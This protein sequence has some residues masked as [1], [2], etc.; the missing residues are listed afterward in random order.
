M[1]T[2]SYIGVLCRPGQRGLWIAAGQSI[3][4][5]VVVVS[6]N[7]TMQSMTLMLFSCLKTTRYLVL[8]S[9]QV[10][11]DTVTPSVATGKRHTQVGTRIRV[12]KAQ[13]GCTCHE[14]T[15]IC[16]SHGIADDQHARREAAHRQRRPVHECPRGESVR[17]EG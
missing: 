10:T 13:G 7:N 11:P 2:R 17:A 8:T 9:A 15:Y 5:D 14:S 12:T 4:V 1:Q 3:N 6:Q 16:D